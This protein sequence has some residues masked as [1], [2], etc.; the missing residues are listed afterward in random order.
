MRWQSAAHERAIKERVRRRDGNRCTVCRIDEKTYKKWRGKTL[1]VHRIVPGSSYSADWGTC[2]TLCDVC[3]NA[4]H[5][6]GNW[7]WIAKDDP[8]DEDELAGWVRQSS[9][10]DLIEEESWRKHEAWGAWVRGLRLAKQNSLIPKPKPGAPVRR[11]KRI[12][13]FDRFAMLSGL[14][15][16]D[17]LDFEAGRREPLLFEAKKLSVALEI[18]LDELATEKEVEEGWRTL[19]EERSH[20]RALVLRAREPKDGEVEALSPAAKLVWELVG[21]ADEKRAEERARALR[22]EEATRRALLPKPAVLVGRPASR[23]PV[24]KNRAR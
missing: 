10:R 5:G 18:S 6:N 8:T 4:L 23:E 19:C 24:H 21:K 17:L 14:S 16:N 2:V 15:A 7:G 12:S 1:E 9:Y 11:R 3:H 13:A 22:V 20:L